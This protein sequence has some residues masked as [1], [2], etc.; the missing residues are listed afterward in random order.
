MHRH[1]RV[2]HQ[3]AALRPTVKQVQGVTTSAVGEK[4]KPLTNTGE[5]SITRASGGPTR[6]R[7]GGCYCMS[8]VFVLDTT[9]QPLDPVHPGAARRLLSLGQASVWRRYPF[10]LILTR[11]ASQALP[12]P[13]R[14]N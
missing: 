8:F 3:P 13:L 5:V 14:L 12:H 2:L 11:A 1:R 10:T 9:H 7:L 4:R 6:A